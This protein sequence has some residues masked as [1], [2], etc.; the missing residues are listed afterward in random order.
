MPNMKIATT[1]DSM[2]HLLHRAGQVADEMFSEEMHGSE[3]TPRQFAVLRVLQRLETASQTDIVNETG[4]DRSTLADIVKRLVSR[5]LIARRRSKADARAYA[6][7]LTA[8][9]RDA[10]RSAEPASERVESR[11]LKSLPQGRRDAFIDSLSQLVD[12]LAAREAAAEKNSPR[13]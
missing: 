4:I 6:V 3:L 1:S 5:N 13:N 11:L 9:G 2:L 12:A 8:S 7:R 10:L